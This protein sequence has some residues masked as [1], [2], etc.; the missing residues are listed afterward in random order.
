MKRV[1][2]VLLTAAFLVSI[3]PVVSAETIEV[4][5]HSSFETVLSMDDWTS[6]AKVNETSGYGNE[7]AGIASITVSEEHAEN[8]KCGRWDMEDSSGFWGQEICLNLAADSNITDWTG[9]KEVWAYFDLSHITHPT[10]IRLGFNNNGSGWTSMKNGE[11]I[12][13]YDAATR[14]EQPPL[15]VGLWGEVT[16]PARF[17]GWVRVPITSL[18]FRADL[19]L[20]L[21]RRVT[22]SFGLQTGE[23][24]YFDSFCILRKEWNRDCGLPCDRPKERPVPVVED[25]PYIELMSFDKW[26]TGAIVG[27]SN[28][29]GEAPNDMYRLLVTS[30]HAEHENALQWSMLQLDGFWGQ[31]TALNIEADSGQTDWREYQE[32]WCYVDIVGSSATAPVFRISSNNGGS[33]WT[34]LTAEAAVYF[35]DSQ[36]RLKEI[37][38]IG[39]W[40]EIFLPSG[41]RGWVRIPMTSFTCYGDYSSNSV[42]RINISFTLNAGETA[43]IDSICALKEDWIPEM[44][45]LPSERTTQAS[46]IAELPANFTMIYD[47][48]SLPP[49][50]S[51]GEKGDMTGLFD[52]HNRAGIGFLAKARNHGFNNSRALAWLTLSVG[53]N[54]TLWMNMDRAEG[55]VTDWRGAQELWFWADASEWKERGILDIYF[56]DENGVTWSTCRA[57][58]YSGT[59][60]IQQDGKWVM[61]GL[62]SWGHV[63]LDAG[64]RGWV[65]I[66]LNKETFLPL[67]N[68]SE[69]ALN[70]IKKI[71]FYVEQQS[72]NNTTVYIDNIGIGRSY[73]AES[74]P[75]FNE[76]VLTTPKIISYKNALSN[77]LNCSAED[78]GVVRY[79][80]S[81]EAKHGKATINAY[82]GTV[83]YRPAQDYVGL[84][85]FTVCAYN[86]NFGYTELT[87]QV[88]VL[89]QE[90]P[91]ADSVAD[92]PEAN[93]AWPVY[94]GDTEL[95]QPDGS[96]ASSKV[97]DMALEG[98]VA[99]NIDANIANWQIDALEKNP[100]II[101]LIHEANSG[102]EK[103]EYGGAVLPWTGEFVGKHLLGIA[104]SYQAAP[105][106]ELKDSGDKIVALLKEAQGGDGYLGIYRNGDR[107]G[108]D[109]YN[110]DVWNH[111]HS[112]CGLLQWSDVAGNQDAFEVAEK[113][114]DYVYDFFVAGN[115]S[116][117][118]AGNQTMNLAISHAF[119][120]MYQHTDKK[121]YLDAA[122][123]I[124]EED[125]PKSG[126]WMNE[127]LSGKEYYETKL[128]R[129]EALHT[130]TTLG[131]LYEITGT[132]KYYTALEN[133]WWSIL[134]TD[135]HNTGGFSSGEQACGSPYST[136]AIET[137]CT[138]AWMG[139]STEYLQ[140]S[141]NSLVA[142]ELELSYFNS[143]LAS[144]LE[145]FRYTTYDSPMQ[146]ILTPSPLSLA[147]QKNSGAVDF[148]CCQANLARGIGSVSQWAVLTDTKGMYLNYYG[149]S[150]ITSVSPSG[151]TITLKQTTQY[152][153]NGSICV[154]IQAAK[155]EEFTLSFRIP[156][157]ATA[158]TV[159]I[160]GETFAAQAGSYFELHRIWENGDV[161]HLELEVGLHYWLGEENYAKKTAVYYGPILLAIEQRTFG[162]AGSIFDVTLQT[163][164]L[165]TAVISD[166]SN[167]DC[168]LMVDTVDVYNMPVRLI[169]MASVHSDMDNL[170]GHQYSTWLQLRHEMDFRWF[171]KGRL[172]IWCNMPEKQG[173]PRPD[174]PV[175]NNAGFMRVAW[176]MENLPA[177]LYAEEWAADTFADQGGGH[178]GALSEVTAAPGKG[179]HKSQALSYSIV[180]YDAN[181]YWANGVDLYPNKDETALANWKGA[182]RLWLWLDAR[183][184]SNSELALDFAINGEKP[185]I[186][187]NI[188][189][190][191]AKGELLKTQEA[192][193][194]SGASFSRISISK[195][196]SGWVGVDLA[197]VGTIDSIK[198]F[199][200]SIEPNA[201][202]VNAHLYID[203]LYLEYEQDPDLTAEIAALDEEIGSYTPEIVKRGD[204]KTIEA[205]ADRV[206]ALLDGENLTE[207]ERDALKALREKLDA[208]L[209]RLAELDRISFAPSIIE[210]AE[211]TWHTKFT[212]GARFCSDASFDE[213]VAV[214][215]DG[216]VLTAEDYTVSEGTTVAVLEPAFLRT[217]SADL[218]SLRIISLNGHADTTF[219]IVHD[220][221]TPQ[222]GDDERLALWF[223]ILVFSATAIAAGTLLKKKKEH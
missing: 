198:M 60:Y 143:M 80:L 189:R 194:Y 152:P 126:D 12:Y 39:Q 100:A 35:Y 81:A 212:D 150:S 25:A 66:S 4:A 49:R 37:S 7:L 36:T 30:E 10:D 200:I 124:V 209:A 68:A 42:K 31:Q 111:Y 158:S 147:F 221:T 149:P 9:A 121:K 215:V 19:N 28:G 5:E 11:A 186:G 173:G 87:V 145:D 135:R 112:I 171:V 98:Y 65:R 99:Q 41:F 95:P 161:V 57:N 56:V 117:D 166:G 21:V 67:Q 45:G 216:K 88:T 1:L 170:G 105:N 17:C 131:T 69:M 96:R 76:A 187:A 102:V 180:K 156:S 43:I 93:P 114:I 183:E 50:V 133:I 140:L 184:F 123:Q 202:D 85:E 14:A 18:T 128:P 188:Y 20:N 192:A 208:L 23:F 24:A 86:E 191:S 58:C 130:I 139:L 185:K 218:H 103:S 79:Q 34:S 146:G 84:D 64:Y 16:I 136:G 220:K 109:G 94:P 122:I 83:N 27:D 193:A 6:G 217:L 33:G 97:N 179:C 210:G 197:D 211:Q 181:L 46:E 219:T 204:R 62:Q 175:Y 61:R 73:N 163:S 51:F 201:S 154:E 2:L 148:S 127:V 178:G 151:Q 134:K 174:Y 159:T 38:T 53:W 132:R 196:F 90:D 89:D 13:L 47:M 70:G 167:D 129:W 168:W 15:A 71:G 207:A 138:V 142:D 72:S 223:G 92:I 144:L 120:L 107:M 169:D 199:S 137:C 118:S 222:T 162:G 55:A 32:L 113:A 78:S 125:W 160:D 75:Q 115:R 214:E 116:F 157:W 82:N 52:M 40:G 190:I 63:T 155:P 106:R 59:Y 177:D 104:Y 77:L 101:G 8:G 29:Y 213:F 3:L 206:D 182:K 141:K 108:F 205:L 26:E 119:A 48:E 44:H 22:V 54:D 176:D 203:N 164:D 165:E 195:G 91:V 172:P 74:A 153:L 110:W